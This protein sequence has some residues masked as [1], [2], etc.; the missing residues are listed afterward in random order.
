ML[1]DL[2][3]FYMA[4]CL[5]GSDLGLGKYGIRVIRSRGASGGYREEQWFVEEPGQ[6]QTLEEMLALGGAEVSESW[7]LEYEASGEG[8]GRGGSCCLTHLL[9]DP[10]ASLKLRTLCCVICRLKPL[11]MHTWWPVGFPFAMERNMQKRL[12]PCPCIC[13]VPPPTFRLGTCLRRD[14]SSA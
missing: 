8:L 6:E 7:A 5:I 1:Q 9:I 14:S 2:P 3:N 12:P 4:A 13:S 10:C 11:A